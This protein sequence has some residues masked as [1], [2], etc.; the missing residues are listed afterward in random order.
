MNTCGRG[1]EKY[2]RGTGEKLK[3]KQ[4]AKTMQTT[5]TTVEMNEWHTQ[6]DELADASQAISQ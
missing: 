4:P 3:K 5:T 2:N 6:R 1:E